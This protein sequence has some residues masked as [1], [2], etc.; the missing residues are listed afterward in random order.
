MRSS[1]VGGPSYAATGAAG[2]PSRQF[3]PP[4]RACP[5]APRALSIAPPCAEEPGERDPIRPVGGGA[6]QEHARRQAAPRRRARRPRAPGALRRDAG[7]RARRARRERRSRRH[8]DGDPRSGGAAARRPL[9]RAGAGR[10]GESRPHLRGQPRRARAGARGRRRNAAAARRHSARDARGHR[11][12]A[13]GAWPG[14]GRHARPLARP[15]RLQ[16]GRLLA[17]G[18][19]AAALRRRQLF[20]HLQR[21][22][23]L[24]IEPQIVDRA[25][26]S[27]STS[28]R[29][30]T[31]R[32]SSPRP[33]RRA[34]T[35][36]WRRAAWP[37]A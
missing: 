33:R 3:G 21:A 25:R 37:N 8:P 5:G 15:P 1:R 13:P 36:I 7:G 12:A 22:R 30:T 11:R 26:A 10:G 17:A 6:G 27:P 4:R 2:S 19:A 35:R 16:C 18:P 29:P 32:R 34:P 9:R 31:S 23:A 24:G 14:A 20:P 28:T